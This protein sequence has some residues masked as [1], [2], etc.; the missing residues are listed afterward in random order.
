MSHASYVEQLG[1]SA[2]SHLPFFWQSV[3]FMCENMLQPA[4]TWT[5]SSDVSSFD[6]GSA[7]PRPVIANR[8]QW[9]ELEIA[10]WHAGGVTPRSRTPQGRPPL[11]LDLGRVQSANP[12]P[13]TSSSPGLPVSSPTK[14]TNPADE[15]HGYRTPKAARKR[16]I[17][18][19]PD[20][21]GKDPKED[22]VP[23]DENC[24]L[25]RSLPNLGTRSKSRIPPVQRRASLLGVGQ[26]PKTP[27]TGTPGTPSFA[28]GS[29]ARGP[30]LGSPGQVY[31]SKTLNP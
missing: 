18:T 3:Q 26:H 12:S 15:P 1:V 30:T 14:P 6:K 5:Q 4:L 28:F 20:A 25:K 7:D 13:A 8:R 22:P 19:N 2:K 23:L 10:S 24:Q 11:R 31:I 16:L 21:E 29:R 27:T 9:R 17:L